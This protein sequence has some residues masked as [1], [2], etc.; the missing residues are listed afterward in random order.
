MKATGNKRNSAAGTKW[1]MGE[2]KRWYWQSMAPIGRGPSPPGQKVQ[3]VHLQKNTPTP[4]GLVFLPF[5]LSVLFFVPGG[6]ELSIVWVA[7]GLSLDA[8]G[9]FNATMSVISCLI[10]IGLPARR[11]CEITLSRPGMSC[12]SFETPQCLPQSPFLANL[13]SEDSAPAVLVHP[14]RQ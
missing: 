2:R 1:L 6:R 5:F 9:L 12:L 11:A 4:P 3:A 10:Q 14:S 7:R 8:R 13:P